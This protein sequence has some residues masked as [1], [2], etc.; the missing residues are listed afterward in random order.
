MR[1]QDVPQRRMHQVR[2]R[3]IA[4]DARVTLGIRHDGHAIADVQRF[5]GDYSMSDQPR[6]GVIRPGN[7]ARAVASPA[8][9]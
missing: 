6:D 2:P 3:M 7:F 9:S 8:L 1:P 4:N 5:L